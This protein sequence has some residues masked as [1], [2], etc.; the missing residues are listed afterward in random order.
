[1]NEQQIEMDESFLDVE[2]PAMGSTDKNETL[3]QPEMIEIGSGS[4]DLLGGKFQND[5]E[6]LKAYKNLEARFHEKCQRLAELLKPQDTND[7]QRGNTDLVVKTEPA[8]EESVSREQVIKEYL[9]TV[10]KAQAAPAVIT[11]ASDIAFGAKPEPKSLR[12]LKQV[13]EHFFR[14][15]E[16]LK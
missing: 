5:G 13:A 2:Q 16:I 15:K 7:S 12:D 11:T 4:K 9:T 3:E 6:L 14:T 8:V 10:A 1:M